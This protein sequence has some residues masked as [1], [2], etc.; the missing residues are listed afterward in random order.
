VK[1]VTRSFS[2]QG[3]SAYAVQAIGSEFRGDIVA[4]ILK[5]M[6]SRICLVVALIG[7]ATAPVAAETRESDALIDKIIAA[8][9]ERQQV[10]SVRS[11][12][13]EAR[14]RAR[15][16]GKEADVIR[17]AEGVSRLKILIRYPNSTEIRVLN[18]NQAWRG[19]SAHN[20]A[21]V[22]GP[23]KGSMVL[24]AAR[25]TL[26]WNL[27]ELK[28]QTHLAKSR[29]SALALEISLDDGLIVRAIIDPQT[30]RIVRS[31]GSLHMGAAEVRFET[32][33]SDFRPVDGVLFA[34][35][36]ENYASGTHTGTTIVKSIQLN[37]VGN[38]LQLPSN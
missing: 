31:E 28:T 3:S 25:A 24:Q 27:V 29:E 22:H 21:L 5:W 36:E 18:E 32:E 14:L 15:A 8:Y 35:H 11:Y 7:A 37:P 19:G 34:F 13:M 12:R 26:P 17:I 2:S 6:K 20:L 30:Y 4:S 9:G 16:R 10:L 38:A 1:K 23:L 33:Y